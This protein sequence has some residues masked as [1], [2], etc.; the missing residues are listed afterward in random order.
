MNGR[1]NLDSEN[2][3]RT[4]LA[5]MLYDLEDFRLVVDA[6]R[7]EDFYSPIRARLFELMRSR[8]KPDELYVLASLPV[9][10]GSS[11]D[12]EWLAITA[13]IWRT[14]DLATDC[15]YLRALT[16][17]RRVHQASMRIIADS[18]AGGALADP[19]EFLNRA[20]T[21][22]GK[23]VSDRDDFAGDEEIADGMVSSIAAF[24]AV[25]PSAGG[26]GVKCGLTPLDGIMGGFKPGELVVIAGRPSMG[27]SAF[28]CQVALELGRD[29]YVQMTS[30]EMKVD[31]IR[32]RM[33]AGA[34]G[35]NSRLIES[36]QL[37]D[38][39]W[40]A[41]QTAGSRLA[42]RKFGWTRGVRSLEALRRSARAAQRKHKR[43]GAVLID[44]LQLMRTEERFASRELE[45]AFMSRELKLLAEE[46][47]CPV[48]AVSQLNRSV[49]SRADK[50]PLMSDLRESGAIEQDADVVLLLYRDDYY[51]K[52]SPDQGVCE[53]N[54]AKNRAG[55][56]GVAK[57]YF[58]GE[59]TRF[60]TVPNA[61][62]FT[63]SYAHS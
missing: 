32:A 6:L 8:G 36:N 35:I 49:E 55:T 53:I 42:V 48:L 28:A 9:T 37:D 19:S 58:E 63:R 51:N 17:A 26:L 16:T 57:V 44:Y 30:L 22:F 31:A 21:L 43:L 52:N 15:T 20:E 5:A 13:R 38:K 41:V 47:N 4:V 50:R 27:K 2:H 54:V 3:E 60:S 29:A 59:C 25:L 46:C 45:I 39:Q 56:T 18:T 23:A 33:L 12:D 34:T 14:S 62:S 7:P 11:A 1:L 24:Q 10:F 40:N 61:G